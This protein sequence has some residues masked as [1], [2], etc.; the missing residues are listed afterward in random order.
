MKNFI[1]IYEF[2]LKNMSYDCN[3]QKDQGTLQT[4]L[5]TGTDLIFDKTQFDLMI[6][7]TKTPIQNINSTT[8]Y[9]N[10]T[11]INKALLQK[12]TTFNT[13]KRIL[14]TAPQP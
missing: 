9:T 2:N 12:N 10:I 3:W 8:Y 5:Q 11:C 14:L 1:T 7:C 6:S 13:Q 4:C